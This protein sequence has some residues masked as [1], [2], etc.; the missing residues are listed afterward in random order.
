[1]CGKVI[2][3]GTGRPGRAA[4][5]REKNLTRTAAGFAR[6]HRPAGLPGA[7]EAGSLAEHVG[8]RMA[9]SIWWRLHRADKRSGRAAAGSFSKRPSTTPSR[10]SPFCVCRT[11]AERMKSPRIRQH[12]HLSSSMYRGG[13]ARSPDL[14]VE[15]EAVN[16]I[17]YGG[18]QSRHPQIGA[19]FLPSTT[20]PPA[21]AS[22]ASPP[23]P[24]PS[25]D[26]KK[27]SPN[28]SRSSIARP[29]LG[30]IGFQ[31]TKS[32]APP[33]SFSLDSASYVTGHQSHHVDGGWTVV[34]STSAGSTE[35]RWESEPVRTVGQT[36]GV[37]PASRAN[38]LAYRKGRRRNWSPAS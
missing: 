8:S 28:S 38:G 2:C 26:S 21:S 10:F 17:D 33:C 13:R 29:P 24:F 9:W 12:R 32:S 11:V 19:L 36:A 18:E 16:P 1:M 7:I 27:R 14:S 4:L 30:R 23:D 37:W 25:H 35:G 31:A 34:V 15:H 20:G 5:V 22:I 6:R 3:S